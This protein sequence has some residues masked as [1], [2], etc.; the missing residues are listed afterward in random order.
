MCK[1]KVSGSVRY[2]NYTRGECSTKYSIEEI[3]GVE[4]NLW[5]PMIGVKGQIDIVASARA[6]GPAL[7][8]DSNK[9]YNLAV[10]V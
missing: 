7:Q 5:C 2:V 6:I 9:P 4:E 3:S 10:E 1:Q 8:F